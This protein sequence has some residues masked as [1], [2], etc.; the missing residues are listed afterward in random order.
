[1]TLFLEGN[2][3]ISIQVQVSFMYEVPNLQDS[4][5]QIR[6][7]IF[8]CIVWYANCSAADFHYIKV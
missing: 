8:V 7:Y 5:Q 1:M 3:E 4:P 2:L 6:V